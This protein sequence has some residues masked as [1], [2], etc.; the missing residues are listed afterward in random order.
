MEVGGWVLP[1]PCSTPSPITDCFLFTTIRTCYAKVTT[2]IKKYTFDFTH[3]L[4][5]NPRQNNEEVQSYKMIQ[6]IA[7][8]RHAANGCQTLQLTLLKLFKNVVLSIAHRLGARSLWSCVISW[9]KG[10]LLRSD[11][12]GQA[13]LYQYNSSDCMGEIKLRNFP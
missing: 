10:L 2:K 6:V 9:Y 13:V 1:A 3:R 5:S 7:T 11:K 4:F 12:L 8:N